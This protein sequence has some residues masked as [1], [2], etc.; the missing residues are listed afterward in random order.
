MCLLLELISDSSSGQRCVSKGIV[1][2]CVGKVS[3]F[4]PLLE[5]QSDHRID[6]RGAARRDVASNEGDPDLQ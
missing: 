6:T 4:L 1:G 5:S 3:G 2:Y